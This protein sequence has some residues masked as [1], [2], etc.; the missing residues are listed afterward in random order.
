M[1]AVCGWTF[2]D[3]SVCCYLW[4]IEGVGVREVVIGVRVGGAATVAVVCD[5]KVYD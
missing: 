5:V 2:G 3:F 1:I 4:S